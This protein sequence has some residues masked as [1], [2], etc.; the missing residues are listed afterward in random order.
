MIREVDRIELKDGTELEIKMQDEWFKKE[1]MKKALRNILVATRVDKTK[2][3]LRFFFIHPSYLR[4]FE[5]LGLPLLFVPIVTNYA[6]YR[7]KINEIIQT[8]KETA[9]VEFSEFGKKIAPI[10]AEVLINP[11]T[12]WLEETE[13][14]PQKSEE[15]FKQQFIVRAIEKVQETTGEKNA[16]KRFVK[17]YVSPEIFSGAL[18][19]AR[20]V[21]YLFS[22]TLTENGLRRFSLLAQEI[23]DRDTELCNEIMDSL[24]ECGL[25]TPLMTISVCMNKY[26]RHTEMTISNRIPEAICGKCKGNTLSVTFTLINEPYLWL[27][28][29][30][31][32]LHAFLY[33]Y[34]DSKS[35]QD[36]VN[37]RLTPDLQCYLTTYIRNTSNNNESEV[38]ALLYSRKNKKALGIEIKIHQVRSQLPSERLRAILNTD[39]KQFMRAIGQIGLTTGCYITNLKISE[40]EIQY[41]KENIIPQLVEGS[42]V[43]IEIISA[44]DE[45]TFLDKLDTLVENIRK[46]T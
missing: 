32:D 34:I 18:G 24:L 40:E 17:R 22:S 12:Q 27:K 20:T 10:I 3:V 41:I 33:S 36:H 42:G 45:T 43:N 23:C 26:C 16:M 2:S 9:N 14:L 37:G 46:P 8:S 38:D 7:S 1:E 5:D 15:E 13:R 25:V 28:D 21:F 39:L 31:L 44:I 6:R 19:L 35:I 29:K 4:A 30:M 11:L